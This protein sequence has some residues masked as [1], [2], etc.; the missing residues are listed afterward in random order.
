LV[1]RLTLGLALIYAGVGHL[2]YSR[3]GFQ[4][5]VP[6]WLPL[7]ADFVVLASGVVEIVLGLGLLT[8]GKVVPI[9]GLAAAAFFIAIFPGNINQLVEGIDAFGLDSDQARVTRLFFQP[10]LVV[11]ALWSTSA[12]GFVQS[13]RHRSQ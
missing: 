5:Q 3:L 6:V 11:L 13:L 9:T 2:S 8:W 10:L 7:D 1:A 4:A 12:I